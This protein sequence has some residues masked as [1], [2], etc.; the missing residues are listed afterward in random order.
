MNIIDKEL[1]KKTLGDIT[2]ISDEFTEKLLGESR[3]LKGFSVITI[4]RC[5]LRFDDFFF[6]VDDNV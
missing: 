6:V 1:I 3:V 4:A 5:D 2:S